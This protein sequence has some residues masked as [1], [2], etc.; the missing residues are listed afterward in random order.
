MQ[1][2]LKIQ[3]KWVIPQE[4]TMYQIDTYRCIDRD[5]YP[6]ANI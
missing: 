1:I 2:N 5:I 4:N 6:K 3:R